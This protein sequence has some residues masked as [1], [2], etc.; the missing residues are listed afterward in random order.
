[1]KFFLLIITLLFQISCSHTTPSIIAS[2]GKNEGGN[3]EAYLIDTCLQIQDINIKKT[4]LNTIY[5]QHDAIKIYIAKVALKNYQTS[6]DGTDDTK[7]IFN[8]SNKK[9]K[10]FIMYLDTSNLTNKISSNIEGANIYQNGNHTTIILPIEKI[11][12]KIIIYNQDKKILKT[13]FIKK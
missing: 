11:Q 8:L 6:R 5:P 13:F 4:C 7:R 2:K 12:E 1:M 3:P 10:K 9:Y